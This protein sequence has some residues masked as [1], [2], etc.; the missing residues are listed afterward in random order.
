[1]TGQICERRLDVS[2]RGIAAGMQ[3]PRLAVR[4]F[5][6]QRNLAVH[7]VERNAHARE[8]GHALR[9][10][11]RQHAHRLRVAESS[12]RLQRVLGVPS[13]RVALAERRRDAA[14]SVQRVRVLDAAL[15][16]DEHGTVLSCGECGEQACDAAADNDEIEMLCHSGR[17]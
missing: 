15:R 8:V 16:H 13:G 7:L 5:E 1:M 14:L 2:A 11:A 9:A 17:G 6:R 3:N 12:A 10:F 4:P